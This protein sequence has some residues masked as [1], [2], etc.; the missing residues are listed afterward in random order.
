[1]SDAERAPYYLEAERSRQRFENITGIHIY[2]SRGR[3]N[4]AG[5]GI[6]TAQGNNA[7]TTS[8]NHMNVNHNNQ[9][10]SVLPTHQNLG[11]PHVQP[12]FIVPNITYPGLNG[13]QTT[14]GQ[15]SSGAGSSGTT[16]ADPNGGTGSTTANSG[17]TSQGSPNT[18]E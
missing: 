6:A 18:N 10:H 14:P 12:T 3:R 5:N 17:S 4:R 8:N 1:M 2:R 13:N 15:N 11:Q 9:P 7:T 16:N